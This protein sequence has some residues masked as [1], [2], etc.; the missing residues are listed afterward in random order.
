MQERIK[1]LNDFTEIKEKQQVVYWMSRDQRVEDNWA[2]IFADGLSKD[3]NCT[4]KI[5][6]TLT[7]NFLLA[8]E[9]QFIFM[10]EG[11]KKLEKKLTCLNIEFII[12]KGKE[13]YKEMID[14]LNK[15]KVSAII[16]DFD[17]LKIKVKWREEVLK[18]I[19]IPFYMVDT[20]NIVPVWVASLK[21]EFAAYTIRPKINHLLG[22][23]L[24]EF[25]KIKKKEKEI[26]NK[27]NW[28]KLILKKQEYSFSSGDASAKEV[29]KVFIKER[30]EGYKNLRNDPS[31]EYQSDLSP[32]LHFGQISSQRIALEV[33][34]S[35][36]NEELKKSFLEELIVRK[37]LADNY[38]YY[39]KN[40]DNFNGFPDWAKKTLNEHREDKREYLYT[41]KELEMSKTHDPLWNGAQKEMVKTGKMHGYLRMYWAK[42]ILEWSK[43]PEDAQK[44]AIYL[45][46]KHSLDGRDANGYTGIAWSIGGVHDRAWN[47]R[48]IFGKIRFM[49]FNSTSKKFNLKEYIEKL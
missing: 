27:N 8:Q 39:N 20:H 12:L 1:K 10:L 34:K 7:D 15:N 29:L 47:E 4:L 9:K 49:S 32:Y 16:T 36:K 38:C 24:T 46:D 41:L 30:L 13:P 5:L 48:E 11:L 3:N 28:K 17:P 42:K 35:K 45:N 26:E 2:L 43:T 18:K 21:Q 22:T 44:H 19:K 33:I 25:P 14:Y 31:K 37:E 40:Y 6:F 23:Y